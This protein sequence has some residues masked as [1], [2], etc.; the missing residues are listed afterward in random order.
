MY[1]VEDVAFIADDLGFGNGGEIVGASEY[2]LGN[3][4]TSFE[5]EG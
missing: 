5:D 1:A 3:R 2:T 4:A